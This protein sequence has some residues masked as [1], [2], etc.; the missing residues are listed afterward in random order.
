MKQS[1]VAGTVREYFQQAERREKYM[2][3][4]GDKPRSEYSF[5]T[6]NKMGGVGIKHAI[7]HFSIY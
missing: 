1:V 7:L 4:Q 2:F 3:F 5:K 6:L